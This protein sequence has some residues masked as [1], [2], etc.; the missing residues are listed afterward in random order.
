[1][2]ESGAYCSTAVRF[3]NARPT[4]PS[5]CYALGMVIYETIS[6]N[7]PFHKDADLIVFMKVVEGERPPR[8]GKFSRTLWWMLEWCWSPKPNDRPSIEDVL[9]CLEMASTSPEPSSP[10]TDEGTDEDDSDWDPA[11]SSSLAADDRAQFPPIHSLQD[12]HLTDSR[13][14][15]PEARPSASS[16]AMWER[17]RLWFIHTVPFSNPPFC[18]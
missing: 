16:W 10:M 17:E 4:I 12:L 7:L 5:D 18:R 3:K 14:T 1:V 13:H 2:D 15:P 8:G 6:G 9:Q 11:M